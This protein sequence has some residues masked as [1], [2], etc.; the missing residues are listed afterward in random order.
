[1]AFLDFSPRAWYIRLWRSCIISLARSIS[2][3][4]DAVAWVVRALELV[5][6]DLEEVRAVWWI[7]FVRNVDLVDEADDWFDREWD[8]FSRRGEEADKCDDVRLLA[9]ATQ[10]QTVDRFLTF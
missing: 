2:A 9:G 5:D 4:V 1:M 6:A 3:G 10:F 7:G 8:G